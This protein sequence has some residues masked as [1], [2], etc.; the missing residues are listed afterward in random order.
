M[1]LKR[2]VQ[3]LYWGIAGQLIIL[4]I[5]FITPR[6][7]LVEYGS[8]V[9]GLFSSVN[10]IFTYV[11][12]LEGG[13]GAATVQALYKPIVY[14]DT[15]SISEILS[16]TRL[17][18]KRVSFYYLICVF[19]ISILY[20]IIITSNLNKI[21]I[22]TV[23]FLQGLSGVINFYFQATL[24]QLL[25]AEG[26]NYII[27]N[28]ELMVHIMTSLAKIILILLSSNIILIQLSYFI[29]SILSMLVYYFYFKKNYGWVNFMAKPNYEALRQK[30]SFLIHHI[31]LLIF[32]NTDMIVLSIFCDF[33]LVSVYSIYNLIF[34]SLN[35]II[36]TINNSILFNL[37]QLYHENKKKY[38]QLHDAYENYYITF[39][40]SIYS[41]CYLLIIPFIAIYT[42][43][44]KDINYIDHR[45]TI[46]FVMIQLLTCTRIV[47]NNLIKIAGHVKQTV[48]RTLIEAFINISLSLILVNIIG[49][50]GVLIGTI[51]ALL[52][53]SID[54]IYYAN[55]KILQRNCNKVLKVVFVNFNLFILV[56]MLSRIWKIELTSYLD[57]IVMGIILCL[58]IIPVFFI[59][60]S[61]TSKESFK[62]LYNL[63][64]SKVLKELKV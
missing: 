54:I 34:M 30:N 55:N 27:S 16:A 9:N 18:Y 1:R 40:F 12:L 5:G 46:L 62:F 2:S 17:Y 6:L 42:K 47:S 24:K 57:F 64:K 50:Y 14:N 58:I 35:S 37:G 45:L 36:N 29:I 61:I 49:I 7:F 15:N 3:N 41:I 26:K 38:L 4:I 44:I 31:S 10:Q 60:N 39:V 56:T 11:A 13:I 19:L 21:Q 43:G 23:I 25:I 28:V 52:Y 63:I 22:G 53:R 33:K 59:V 20:P 32:S 8:E 48:N 51:V